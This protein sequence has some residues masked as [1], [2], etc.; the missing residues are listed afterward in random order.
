[1]APIEE[2]LWDDQNI[3]HIAGHKVTPGEVEEVVFD[4]QSVF[5]DAAQPERPGRLIV[6]GLTEA[7]RHLAVYLDTPAGGR[8]YPV[9]ARSMTAK[10]K[11]AYNSAREAGR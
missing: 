5:F 6:L 10:E 1:M 2:L 11:R 7:G 9:S 8:S 4:S 3:T